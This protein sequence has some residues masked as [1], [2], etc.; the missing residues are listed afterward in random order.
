MG[1]AKSSLT[2]FGVYDTRSVQHISYCK[3]MAPG[4][5]YKTS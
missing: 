5:K 4:I 3:T 1:H 2:V